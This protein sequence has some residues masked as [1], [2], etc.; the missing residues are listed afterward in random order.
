MR[1]SNASF[2]FDV[3]CI[4]S[5]TN[6]FNDDGDDDDGDDDGNSTNVIYKRCLEPYW[7]IIF[8]IRLYYKYSGVLLY[9]KHKG[10]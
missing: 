9:L 3:F 10:R 2:Y 5:T 8:W 1:N 6:V 7:T 4:K